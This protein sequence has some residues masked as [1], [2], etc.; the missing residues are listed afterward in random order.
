MS[1]RA[2]HPPVPPALA[3]VQATLVLVAVT[4]LVFVPELFR[5]PAD[6]ERAPVLTIAWVVC[7]AGAAP[8]AAYVINRRKPIATDLLRTLLLALPQLPLLVL[9][10]RADVWLDV[11]RG[12]L[13]ENSGEEAMS[14]GIG[15]TVAVAFG[16]LVVAL[17]ALAARSGTPRTNPAARVRR[18]RPGSLA[19]GAR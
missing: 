16:L 4:T 18:R 3:V 17:V 11:Q 2:T 19:N 15:T 7:L 9:L 6:T 10:A 12:Y 14:Y 13:L 5:D 8:L 1:T